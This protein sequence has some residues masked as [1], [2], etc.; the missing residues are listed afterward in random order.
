MRIIVAGL[1]IIGVCFFGNISEGLAAACKVMTKTKDSYQCGLGESCPKGT[2][3]R[4][5][6]T[7]VWVAGQ[8]PNATNEAKCPGGVAFTS[9]S[10]PGFRW[11]SICEHNYPD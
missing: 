1:L 8:A 4:W 10:F 7:C 2:K 5:L 11:S 9:H 6:V 3:S